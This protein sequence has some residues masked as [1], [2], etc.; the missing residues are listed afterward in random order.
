MTVTL[1]GEIP[2]SRDGTN[3][4]GK[5]SYTRAF[6]IDT[7]DILDDAYTASGV[8]GLP[9][10]GDLHPSDFNAYCHSVDIKCTDPWRGWV[11]TANYQTNSAIDIGFNGGG[12]GGGSGGGS[13]PSAPDPIKDQ[14]PENDTD[15]VSWSSE[16]YQ[17]LATTG[18]LNN[19][20]GRIPI[21]NTAGDPFDPAAVKDDSL[22][23][24]TIVTKKKLGI[25]RVKTWVN[26]VNEK[27][28][29]IDGLAVE[30]RQARIR[31]V[32][33]SGPEFRNQ[34]RFNTTTILIEI[35]LGAKFTNGAQSTDLT[36]INVGFR[37]LVAGNRVAMTDLDEDGNAIPI[38][39]PVGLDINGVR[40]AVNLPLIERNYRVYDLLD[41]S[42]LPFI[43]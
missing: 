23:V 30:E 31:S 2:G 10:I 33:I 13:N 42:I 25:N 5:R 12:G 17:V 43:P 9:L 3:D 37:E 29:T 26:S 21:V 11:Y 22:W 8:A 1:L 34:F 19:A 15:G 20:G 36:L 18:F 6:K 7:D 24:A 28:F 27:D 4:M 38:A 41:F 39:A 32:S 16:Q 35:N 40:L 14:N